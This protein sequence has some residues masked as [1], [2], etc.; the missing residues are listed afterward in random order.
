MSTE[1]KIRRGR[2]RHRQPGKPFFKINKPNTMKTNR[3]K[4]ILTAGLL[5]ALA[6]VQRLGP[7]ELRDP[8]IDDHSG[9][10]RDRHGQ[11]DLQGR[12][13]DPGDRQDGEGIPHLHQRP[14]TSTT[15][16]S[17]APRPMRCRRASRTHRRGG[18]L[19]RH[20]LG[21]DGLELAFSDRQCRHR[22]LHVRRRSDQR[23]DGDRATAEKRGNHQRHVV[24][25]G[26]RY[27]LPRTGPRRGR[28]VSDRASGL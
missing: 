21:A 16:A 24:L 2:P 9:R 10:R 4:H 25:V 20:L 19:G 8:A 7:N 23:A 22:L 1:R 17:V 12:R 27:W 6:F 3:K 26:H 13:A 5:G 15:T 18:Q 14:R 28:E 11:A